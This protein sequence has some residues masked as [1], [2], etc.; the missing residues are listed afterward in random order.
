MCAAVGA[1]LT[2]SSLGWPLARVLLGLEVQAPTA[3]PAGA[4]VS[5]S[6]IVDSVPGGAEVKVDGTAR[7]I[8]PFVTIQSCRINV[9]I[10]L[11]VSKKGYATWTRQEKCVPRDWLRVVAELKKR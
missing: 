8:T 10:E 4:T 11:E 5:F 7:G 3:R 2:I 6:F 9:P 1:L